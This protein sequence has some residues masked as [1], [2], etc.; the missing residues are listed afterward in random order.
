MGDA[1]GV[2]SGPSNSAS[3]SESASGELR[4]NGYGEK[5]F[6]S[7]FVK[8]A[9]AFSLLRP[10]TVE[11]LFVLFRV[12][13]DERYRRW[14]WDIFNAMNKYARLESLGFANVAN[15]SSTETGRMDKMESFF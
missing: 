8:P 3:S 10:E 14:G 9:D 1:G 11:S 4:T 2:P 15:V 6:S 12:T 7:M 5:I 13:G